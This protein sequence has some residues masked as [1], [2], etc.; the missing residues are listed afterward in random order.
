M[1]V[2]EHYPDLVHS[3]V[4]LSPSNV[5]LCSF[6][7]CAGPAWTFAGA[8]VP[9]TRT[10]NQAQPTDAPDAILPVA[11]IS[12]P[13][14]L[15]CGDA[16]RIWTSCP[17]AQALKARPDAAHPGA[18][19]GLLSYP[20]AGHGVGFVPYPPANE[21]ANTQGRDPQANQLADD[22]LWPKLL[23]FLATGTTR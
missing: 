9:F 19:H 12:G 20:D 22:D 16:D 21:A 1:L 6:P 8:P 18:G 10:I 23:T 2:A 4:G 7:G 3:V 17:Y 11:N 13:V 15:A 14:L 5:S